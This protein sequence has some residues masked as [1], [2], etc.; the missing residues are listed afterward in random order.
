MMSRVLHVL[1]L[2]AA[3][4][5]ETTFLH[6]LRT[7]HDAPTARTPLAHDVLALAGGPLEA[8]VRALAARTIV[9]NDDEAIAA[10]LGEGYD[11]VHVLFERCAHRLAPLVLTRTS[12]RLVYGKGYDIGAMYRMDG[13]FDWLAE[14]SLL[15]ACDAV[16]FTTDRLADL[17][18]L[19]P[20]R[21]HILEK[22]VD[23]QRFARVPAATASTPAR[24]LAIANLH[25]RK[26]LG[27]LVSA[28]P[29]LVQR[30]PGAHVRIVG[31]GSSHER[32][33]LEDLAVR[34]G[35]RDALQVVGPVEDVAAEL[36]ASRVAV[37]PSE[38]EGVPTALLEAMAAGRPVVATR[39]GHIETIVED[40]A[41]GFLVSVGDVHALGDQIAR[42]LLDPAL[43]D[44]LGSAGRERARAHDVQ[45]IAARVLEVL[46]AVPG[47]AVRGVA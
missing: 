46:T 25:R 3:G 10:L 9:T 16:T 35:V 37:L 24:V 39:V 33:S 36:G 38:C 41:E 47:T 14:E 19:P 5:M 31:A 1:E 44:R 29:S 40:G 43:A 21:T 30:I 28:L 23:W 42:L 13:T 34:L 22:A 12:A 8:P 7:W 17:Y 15:A 20:G 18:R 32:A 45:V 11:T 26:R 4:G 6:M 27:D 2:L